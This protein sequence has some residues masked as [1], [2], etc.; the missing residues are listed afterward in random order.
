MATRKSLV[1][2]GGLFQELNTSADKL[3]FGGNTSAD[4]AE[5]TNLY[6][7]DARARA[8]ISVTDSGGDG[9][10]AYNNSTGVITYTGPSSSEARA[11]FSVA[12]GSGLTYNSGTGEFGTSA[13]PNGQ[14]ANSSLTIG[15]TSVSLGATQGTFAGLTS[16]ASGTL[17]AGVEDAANAI[18]IGSGNIIFEGSTADANETLLTADEATGGDKTLNLPNE[19]GTVK[20]N[21][22]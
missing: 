8:A 16:L 10:L 17:I 20:S 4:L 9:S 12:S 18:E 15:S 6:F 5:N 19:T 22:T 11:H 1:I 14:L 3:D 13:I 21:A 2:V 7:T